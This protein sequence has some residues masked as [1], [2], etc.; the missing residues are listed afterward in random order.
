MLRQ[1]LGDAL[2]TARNGSMENRRKAIATAREDIAARRKKLIATVKEQTPVHPAWLA[3]CLNQLKS[4]NAIVISELGVPIA[5]LNL[6]QP[7]SAI[8][9]PITMWVAPRTCRH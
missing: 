6:T 2:K 1:C 5:G 8:R 9:S 7:R 4:D 3:H